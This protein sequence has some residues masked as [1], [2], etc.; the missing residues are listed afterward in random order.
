MSDRLT[1][2]LERKPNL[3]NRALVF[4]LQDEEIAARVEAWIIKNAVN[5]I[6]FA[7]L[8]EELGLLTKEKLLVR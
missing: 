2:A 1:A 3:A 5:D 8:G 6:R 7:R 4:L